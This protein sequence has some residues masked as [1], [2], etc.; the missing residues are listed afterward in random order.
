MGAAAAAAPVAGARTT[1]REAPSNTTSTTA[2]TGGDVSVE[3]EKD[4]VVVFKFTESPLAS[5]C[6]DAGFKS[7]AAVEP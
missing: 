4:G 6:E 5:S 1:S 3:V 7:D 2:A